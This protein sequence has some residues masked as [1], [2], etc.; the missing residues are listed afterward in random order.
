MARPKSTRAHNDVL[1]A[2][3][4]LFAERGIEGTSMDAI[5]QESGVSKA[6]IYK[7]WPDKDAL[8]LEAMLRIH[9]RGVDETIEIDSGDLR[10]DL[11][12]VLAHRPPERYDTLRER[13]T[14]HLLGY[15]A[16]NVAFANEWRTRILQP[17]RAQMLKVLQ[18]GM[19]RGELPRDLDTD[20]AT[21]LLIGPTM[22]GWMM[23][24]IY[25]KPLVVPP[26]AIV[27]MFLN[28]YRRDPDPTPVRVR[29]TRRAAHRPGRH[30]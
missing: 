29:A 9:G 22:Y 13:V 17:A 15:C 3:A 5:A 30:A 8:L 11:I 16:R 20:I 25:G 19:S 28:T 10:T 26:V 18:R 21:A 4:A 27:E 2:A 24:V 7:H 14:P 12:A 23:K 1:D 6:T